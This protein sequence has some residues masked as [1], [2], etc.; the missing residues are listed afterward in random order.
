MSRETFETWATGRRVV[1][2]HGGSEHGRGVVVG[3]SGSYLAVR[4]DGEGQTYE[5]PAGWCRCE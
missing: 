5:W 3:V 4:F 1:V 2:A